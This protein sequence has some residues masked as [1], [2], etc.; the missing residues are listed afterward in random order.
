MAEKEVDFQVL[1]QD[2]WKKLL[3]QT[4]LWIGIWSNKQ[5]ICFSNI[6]ILTCRCTAWS[7][8]KYVCVNMTHRPHICVTNWN[9]C[10]I[11]LQL[12]VIRNTA[13]IM[14]VCCV[15]VSMAT[16]SQDKLW[17]LRG[18]GGSP[19][20]PPKKRGFSQRIQMCA[21]S[22]YATVFFMEIK[23]TGIMKPCADTFLLHLL[24]NFNRHLKWCHSHFGIAAVT[25]LFATVDNSNNTHGES[26]KTFSAFVFSLSKQGTETCRCDCVQHLRLLQE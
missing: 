17:K 6:L 14:V 19:P 15:L 5:G 20:P 8:Y 10:I 25:E 23:I 7:F 11:D 13:L 26:F 24:T 18:F 22:G 3:N 1:E 4:T 12:C 21:I 9:R 2:F 16:A